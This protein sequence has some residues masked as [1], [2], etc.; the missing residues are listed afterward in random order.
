V[1]ALATFIAV[2]LIAW[3]VPALGCWRGL[4]LSIGAMIPNIIGN[5]GGGEKTGFF[6]HYHSLYYPVLAATIC[7]SF[8][9][10]YRRYP[11]WA[12]SVFVVWLAI[13]GFA[14]NVNTNQFDFRFADLASR[15]VMYPFKG[16]DWDHTQVLQR[17]DL[18]AYMD[19]FPGTMIAT[20]ESFMPV[21]SRHHNVA[22]Y[23]LGLEDADFVVVP[24]SPTPG[25]YGGVFSYLGNEDAERA[26]QCLTV[27]MRDAGYRVQKELAAAVVLSRKQWEK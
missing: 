17:R 1:S 6:T 20:T 25:V 24:Y 21:L 22:F 23:P 5:Y 9:A 27:K 10:S 14:Y 12:P 4:L 18:A 16:Y 8:V 19:R 7:L 13:A 26:N 15:S 3:G 11:R 2:N